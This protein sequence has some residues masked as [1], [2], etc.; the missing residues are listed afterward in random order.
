MDKEH[1]DTNPEIKESKLKD[2]FAD[3][4]GMMLGGDPPDECV[5]CELF[6]KCHKMTVSACLQ[7]ISDALHLITQN[8]LIT[9]KLM[10]FQ[11]LSE[12]RERKRKKKQ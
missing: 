11:E 2:C 4:A 1:V 10:G 5:E 8:G 6:E 9:G 3:Q 7:N 12:Y